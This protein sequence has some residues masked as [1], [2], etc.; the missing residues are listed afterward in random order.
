MRRLGLVALFLGLMSIPARA[1]LIYT[2]VSGWDSDGPLSAKITINAVNGGLD[3]QME[4]LMIGAKLAKGQAI[5][6]LSFKLGR[7]T[8]PTALTEILGDKV[9]SANFTPGKPFPG[10]VT[11]T[12]VDDHGSGLG[13]IDHWGLSIGST[14]YLATAGKGAQ[15]RNPHYM[16]LPSSGITGNGK[17]LADGHFD[18]Y[19]IGPVDFFV[20]I[21]GVTQN[22]NL[23]LANFSNLQVG[24][25]TGVDKWLG[26][27]GHDPVSVPEPS[28]LALGLIGLA[29]MVCYRRSSR[30]K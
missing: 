3:V 25:G 20:S 1:E 24:F 14:D 5:S 10:S 30:R 13:F 22:T 6:A 23:T 7:L 28:S 29:G 11:I 16:I 9:S 18:P 15:G 4:N 19:L 8:A 2:T 17:S 26:T 21:R 12:P 27:V